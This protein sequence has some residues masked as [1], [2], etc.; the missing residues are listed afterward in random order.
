MIQL[1]KISDVESLKRRMKGRFSSNANDQDNCYAVID[2]VESGGLN[3][4]CGRQKRI[5]QS[6]NLLKVIP[7]TSAVDLFKT[8]SNDD[9]CDCRICTSEKEID[10]IPESLM[11]EDHCKESESDESY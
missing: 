6:R 5:S 3:P 11:V 4:D 9:D 8:V 7:V 1:T 10:A 2:D